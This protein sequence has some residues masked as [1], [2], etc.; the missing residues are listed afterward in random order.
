MHNLINEFVQNYTKSLINQLNQTKNRTHH[1]IRD[2]DNERGKLHTPSNDHWIGK[3][4]PTRHAYMRHNTVTQCIN[5]LNNLMESKTK[6]SNQIRI[7]QSNQFRNAM[8][9]EK[10]NWS[11]LVSHVSCKQ[12]II[13]Q[14]SR[15][16]TTAKPNWTSSPP[17]QF[18]NQRQWEQVLG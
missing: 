7:Q 8:K 17:Y 11:N 10:E 1:S 5:Q 18:Q 16:P 4:N 14:L 12:P 13:L 2:R 15:L 3:H 6:P 9:S